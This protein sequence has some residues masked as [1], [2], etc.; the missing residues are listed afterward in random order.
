M[1][2][3]PNLLSFPSAPQSLVEKYRPRTLKDFA[4]ISKP[5]EI[6]QRL[7]E[8]PM[9]S[10]WLLR[11]QP[12]TGK[13]TAALALA[14][15]IPAEVMHIG[16]QDLT[17][18]RINEVWSRCFNMPLFGYRFWMV[19][20][21][22]VDTGSK[23]AIDSLL[24]KLDTTEK[25]PNTIFV[26]TC[27]DSSNLHP[28]LVSRCLTLDFSTY[29]IQAEAVQLLTRIWEQEAPGTVP[30]NIA[31]I[32]KEAKGNIREALGVLQLELMLS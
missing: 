20:L 23:Q 6:L 3:Q 8:R 9:A 21:D 26:L 19:L 31:A 24:S 1:S 4:G 10:N 17:V 11:G 16:S 27:N 14:D 13:T 18:T 28:R 7:A 5:K 22:E 2:A 12:G 30:P 25:A 32:V 29:G 15:A